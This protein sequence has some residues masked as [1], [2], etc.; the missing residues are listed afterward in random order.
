MLLPCPRAPLATGPLLL[1]L[2]CSG[3]TAGPV[4]TADTV[5]SAPPAPLVWDDAAAPI[6]CA[7]GGAAPLLDAALEDAD[8]PRADFAYTD[9]E[10][11]IWGDLVDNKYVLSWFTT[12]HHDPEQAPCFAGQL[13]ADV[14][15]ALTTAH[16]VSSAIAVWS[17]HLDVTLPD[18]DPPND[19][20]T[21]AGIFARF[22]GPIEDPA[23]S[24]ASLVALDPDLAA[25]VGPILSTIADAL[26]LRAAMDTSVSEQD[27]KL[28]KQLF[29]GGSGMVLQS[30]YLTPDYTNTDEMKW[31]GKW[32][33]KEEGPRQVFA[34]AARNIAFAIEQANLTR[35]LG[36]TALTSEWVFHTSAGAVR[37]SPASDDTHDDADGTTLFHLELGGDDLWT[38]SA[39]ATIAYDNP[40]SIAVDLGGADAYGYEEVPSSEDPVGALVSDADG[41]QKVS[42]YF[43]SESSNGRQ[44]SGRYGVGMLFDLGGAND[45]YTSLR[46]SQGFGS[47]GV[48]VLYDDGGDD[49]YAGEA[50]V[51]GAS[52]FGL[53]LL[54]DGGGNDS[55]VAWAFSQG[56]GYSGS[57]GLLADAGDGA[58]TYWSDPGNNYGGTTLYA[59][60]QLPN[61]EGN[62]S[63]T[64]GAGF[65]LRGDSVGVYM[66]GGLGMLRDGGGDDVYTAGVFAQGTGYW[67]GT[68]LLADAGGDDVYDALYYAEGGAAHYALGILVDGG[69]DDQHNTLFAPYYMM[70]GAGHDYSVGVMIDESGDDIVV[71]PGLALGASNCQGRGV[72]ADNDGSDT[73]IVSSTY[74]TGLGNHSGEC[75][76]RSDYTG[77]SAVFMDSGADADDY[78]WPADDTARAPADN[79]SFGLAWEGT[80]DEHGGAVDGDGETG[81]HAR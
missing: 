32:Y 81:F 44:G 1:L 49:A 63:F 37:V 10:W 72:Y 42:G 76:G 73:Y 11:A 31:F 48:G 46:M 3:R 23:D 67:E 27:S 5:D 24:A 51:Q 22:P 15:T 78:Q 25:A 2:A 9:A 36:S 52:V 77:S 80:D 57:G 75:A 65:G 74:S 40:A 50:G 59:S 71:V 38:G 66:A 58:D 7:P 68:G 60:P 45:T 29:K 55:Y 12:V 39:G 35:F 14:D 16:P 17:T 69:G 79:T 28:P 47:M 61:G 26:D 34:I 33:P 62:S 53:G 19:T 21:L 54:L 70:L 6:D 8:L 13:Q 64:Q 41:R 4:D 20:S 56:F 43:I 30:A 18:T